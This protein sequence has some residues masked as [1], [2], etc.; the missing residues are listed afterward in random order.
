MSSQLPVLSFELPNHE[1]AALTQ[2]SALKTQNWVI[3][4]V[5]DTGIGIAS[6]QLSQLFQP[7]IHNDTS[8]TRIYGGAGL[9]LAICRRYCQLMGGDLTV[10]SQL[11]QGSTFT[12][13]LPASP[14]TVDDDAQEPGV[15][16]QNTSVISEC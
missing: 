3:F 12:I 13:H 4:E 15:K 2:N 5:T 10:S 16:R 14:S 1:T 7:F 8:D 6:N 11:G 9:G